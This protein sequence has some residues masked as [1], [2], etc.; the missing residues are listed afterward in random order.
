MKQR[1]SSVPDQFEKELHSMSSIANNST[2][3]NINANRNNNILTRCKQ[4]LAKY[5]KSRLQALILFG[6]AARQEL[7][8][9]SDIDL[10]VVLSSPF[11]YCQELTTIVDLLYPLQLEASH[12]ISAK[13]AETSDF[14]AGKIQL[15]RNIQQEGILL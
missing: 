6:S 7:T 11:D 14:E 15:Y 8:P 5:Y 12:W 3:E 10:L 1:D 9:N 4:I 13:P 2:R